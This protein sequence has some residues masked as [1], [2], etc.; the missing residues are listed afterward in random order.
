MK[1]TFVHVMKIAALLVLF[2]IL[3]MNLGSLIYPLFRVDI[4]GMEMPGLKAVL[5]GMIVMGLIQV[6][7]LSLVAGRSRLGWKSLGWLLSGILFVINHLLNVIES[8]V[9]MRNILSVPFQMAG[10][11]EGVISSLIM[12]F[13]A[14]RLLGPAAGGALRDSGFIR[15]KKLI[16]PWAGWT[17]LWFLIYFC[18]GFLIPNAVEGVM[19]YYFGESGAMDIGLVPLGYLM[20]IPRASLWILT[21]IFLLSGLKGTWTEKRLITGLVFA[22]LMSSN[23]LIPNFVMPDLVRLSH[24]PE[25]LF[26][27][28]LWGFLL[29]GNLRKHFRESGETEGTVPDQL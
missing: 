21:A 19:D 16:L 2:L 28:L 4:S 12:G 18:A 5:S 29:A 3:T 25:I 6:F 24:L 1:K 23:L 7:T 11:V 10:L 26:A 8:L 27:N 22:L 9:F 17:V 14:A 20:Q 15:S 13:A